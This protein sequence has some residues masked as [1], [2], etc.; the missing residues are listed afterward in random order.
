MRTPNVVLPL[1]ESLGIKAFSGNSYLNMVKCFVCRQ[2]AIDQRLINVK[3]IILSNRLNGITGDKMQPHLLP[4]GSFPSP[5][6]ILLKINNVAGAEQ[7]SGTGIFQ[8]GAESC[9]QLLVDKECVCLIPEVH[10]Q[11]SYSIPAFWK[12]NISST[13]ENKNIIIFFHF[14]KE[15]FKKQLSCP[16]YQLLYPLIHSFVNIY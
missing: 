9:P 2:K 5:G 7:R 16:K 6:F 1:W 8:F 10:I 12:G 15:K 13:G 11:L 4:R 14:K 3:I